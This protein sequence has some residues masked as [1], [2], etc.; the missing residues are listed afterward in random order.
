M[1]NE[2]RKILGRTL[3]FAKISG[4]FSRVMELICSKQEDEMFT[5]FCMAVDVKIVV[6]NLRQNFLVC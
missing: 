2:E 3:R 5:L 4:G 6:T 1:E